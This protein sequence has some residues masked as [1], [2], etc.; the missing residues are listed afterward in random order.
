MKR[1]HNC[2]ILKRVTDNY[3]TKLCQIIMNLLKA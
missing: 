3:N 1:E 2:A